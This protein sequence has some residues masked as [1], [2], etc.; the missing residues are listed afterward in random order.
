[1]LQCDYQNR[2]LKSDKESY[3][4]K[5]IISDDVRLRCN[6]FVT[7]FGKNQIFTLNTFFWVE[8]ME[9][10]Q[11]NYKH[12]LLHSRYEWTLNLLGKWYLINDLHVDIFS[13]QNCLMC[14]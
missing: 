13:F 4:K 11:L 2:S 12:S 14:T 8:Q 10:F 1:M 9:Y 5:W 7:L 6:M 3:L